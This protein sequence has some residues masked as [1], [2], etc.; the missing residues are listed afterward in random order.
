MVIVL[1]VAGALTLVAGLLTLLFAVPM[2]DF[3]FGETLLV[4]GSIVAGAGLIVLA[5][6]Q[7]IREIR[8]LQPSGL[9]VAAAAP[10][11]EFPPRPVP[12]TATIPTGTMPPV[13]P[14]FPL[15]RDPPAPLA[16]DRPQPDAAGD[17]TPRPAPAAP[18][19]R[20]L[21]QRSPLTPRPAGERS[22]GPGDQAEPSP[23]P[24]LT[25]GHTPR[26]D[27]SWPER[28]AEGL[29]K[30]RRRTEPAAAPEPPRAPQLDL[31]TE[32]ATETQRVTVLKSGVVDGMAYTLYSDGSIEAELAEGMVRF[33]SIEALRAHL[34]K[35]S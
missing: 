22:E 12:P 24:D 28:P 1:T 2:R 25:Q 7:V 15:R 32:S 27:L 9:A 16:A 6:A 8:K 10:R 30:R 19:K 17:V 5:L 34:D 20:N 18:G 23:A 33:D 13:E 14:P 4:V 31:N 26:A 3:S 29:W 11:P 35:P 21:F